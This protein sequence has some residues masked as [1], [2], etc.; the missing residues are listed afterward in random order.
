MFSFGN[1]IHYRE[2]L[3]RPPAEADSLI[4][5]AAYGCPHN[6][7][8]FCAMYKSVPYRLRPEEELFAEIA[9][10]GR[11]F[12]DT[13]RVFLA[14]GDV[15]AFSYPR[16]LRALEQLNTCFP[17]L[18]RV[19]LYANGSS[20]A[21]KSD[22]ELAELRRRKL[23]T[24]YLGLETGDD[25]LLRRVDKGEKSETMILA[26]RRA[27]AAGLRCSVMILLGLG[28][29]EGSA[30][31]AEATV[32]A[33]NAMQPRLLSALRFVPIPGFSPFDGF[34]PVSEYGAVAE[35]RQIIAGLELERTV[36][37][38]NHNSNPVPLEGR[39]PP[40]KAALLAGLDR[41]LAGDRLD[42][43]GPGQLPLSL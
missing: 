39:F 35:L 31:H 34:R 37:R 25:E 10:A 23:T 29:P 19:N 11:R 18:A 30:R 2:P 22:A 1:P 28:G 14:D 36:F 5:Q 4:F 13:R 32:R 16:L 20:I 24:L 9:A 21:G 8:R 27:Q 38:A 42:R 33:L 17:R 6:R 40:D 41:L 12:P 43:S 15:M 3:F 7:C 26:V